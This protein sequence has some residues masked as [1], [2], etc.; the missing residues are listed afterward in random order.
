MTSF[1]DVPVGS[2]SASEAR[3]GK[4]RWTGNGG[5]NHLSHA[6]NS[7]RKTVAHA[8]HRKKEH[9][10]H[11]SH[12]RRSIKPLAG[13]LSAKHRSQMVCLLIISTATPPARVCRRGGLA[14]EAVSS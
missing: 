8:S 6:P 3:Y 10:S 14:L 11:R 13:V 5:V 1:G 7:S 12:C 2:A 4:R 9:D